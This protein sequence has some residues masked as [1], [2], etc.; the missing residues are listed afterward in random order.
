MGGCGGVRGGWMGDEGGSVGVI[1]V[2]DHL[3]VWVIC[4]G[5]LPT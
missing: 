5:S 4:G 2:L 1:R 3:W